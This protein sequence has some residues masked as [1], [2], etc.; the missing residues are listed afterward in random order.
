MALASYRLCQRLLWTMLVF[1]LLL[2]IQGC[3]LFDFQR[4]LNRFEG[5]YSLQTGQVVGTTSAPV[6]VGALEVGENQLTLKTYRVLKE[7][8]AFEL[9]VPHAEYLIFAFA[10]LN[11]D[12]KLNDNEPAAISE[13]LNSAPVVSADKKQRSI[14]LQ[15][16][17]LK[18]DDLQQLRANNKIS[19][20]LSPIL[21]N[22][23]KVVA[24][25]DPKLSLE[26]GK[27][28]LWKPMEFISQGY[29]GIFFL[30]PFS[31]EKTPVVFIH[32][33]GGAPEHFRQMLE[34]LDTER[35]QPWLISYPSSFG[36]ERIGTTIYRILLKLDLKH[37]A[38]PM[39]LVSHSMGGLVARQVVAS[40]V[41]DNNQRMFKK[42]LTIAAPWGGNN[43]AGL[44]IKH[45]PV[46]MPCWEDM[47]PGSP[48]LSRWQQTP[49]ALPHTLIFAYHMEGRESESS[50]G[51]I[52]LA[53]QLTQVV[54]DNATHL[55]GY[56]AT[57]TGILQHPLFL[58][59]FESLIE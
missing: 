53:S 57:H 20:G 41:E 56:D 22:S 2:S 31:S 23:G 40:A 36:L 7:T 44:G 52:S 33:A 21:E 27:M 32:G 14:T 39:I 29:G 49:L 25:D 48:F 58:E 28:G 26:V 55:L 3:A 4:D 47:S 1:S 10:D 9:I 24:S 5:S 46:V 6:I 17:T 15:L 51:T 35:F 12:L 45:S 42:L 37:R 34:Q 59:E 18:K 30:Q 16:G 11:K 50:D 54:Q 8:G 38:K 19:L 43:M 13:K